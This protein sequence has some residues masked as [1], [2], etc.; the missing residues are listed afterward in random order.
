MLGRAVGVALVAA[1]LALPNA[2]RAV[3]Q[4]GGWVIESFHV[5][6]TVRADGALEV[7]EAIDVDFG[8][9]RRHGIFR[10]IPV[11]HDFDADSLRVLRID[12][13]AVT[14][15][16][17]RAQRVERSS[18]GA[19]LRLRIGD[20]NRTISGRQSYRVRYRVQGALNA[21]PGHDEL[22]WNAT[23]TDWPVPMRAVS[24][25]VS[26]PDGALQEAACF[27]GR[28]GATDR[29][30]VASGASG[31]DYTA[32]RELA[33]R[34]GLTLVAALRKGAVPE[35]APILER[36][37]RAL[38]EYFSTGPGALLAA[39]ATFLAG[40]ALV[41][42]SW[43]RAGRDKQFTSLY[44]L[45]ADPTQQTRP[46]GARPQIVVEYQPPEGLRP[47]EMGL[48]LDE[49]ADPKD[50]TATIIDLAVRGFLTIREVAG[51][52]L[53]GGRFGRK[54]WLLERRR[55]DASELLAYERL[56]FEGLFRDGA[57][58]R[59]SDLKDEY[60]ATLERVASELY[61]DVTE[62]G[63][64]QGNPRSARSRWL[65]IGLFSVMAGVLLAVALGY[66]FGLGLVG[67]PVALL[68][69]AVVPL[70]RAMASR[71][72]HGSELLRR[73]LGFREYM[74]TAE[75]DRQRFN[76]QAHIFSEYLPF[77]IVF[78]CVERWARAFEGIEGATAATAAWYTGSGVH[79][80]LAFSGAIQGLNSS[81]S[82]AISSTPSSS[83]SS[84]FSGGFSG[85]GMGGGGG[86]SW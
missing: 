64:F 55:S 23:G 38:P 10:E 7:E 63:W 44:Y 78:G 80:P 79:G 17:G 67:V 75:T 29:C 22:Y 1:M 16:R 2:P 82:S 47:A 26:V 76:E 49:R 4:D 48:L 57:Q 31:A 46:L 61:A 11:R 74:V 70:S 56:A 84:G 37:P 65:A 36:R 58:V 30:R 13:I 52:G 66:L 86:G 15:A 35:P 43:W 42:R 41:A 6:V 28:D 5:E 71:S 54:D 59:L 73:V 18:E 33:A 39:L 72:A 34:E 53:L 25:R 14:D 85:G 69:L 12:R 77:A 27:E 83:G 3:A 9:L 24:A 8:A 50:V 45:T 62:R 21:F 40:A 81:V 51:G 19:N 32:T 60:Y 68:G 20:P